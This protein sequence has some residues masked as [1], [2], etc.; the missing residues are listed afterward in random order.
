M[1]LVDPR[2]SVCWHIVVGS[3][4]GSFVFHFSCHHASSVFVP[5]ALDF[6]ESM[7]VDPWFEQFL[8]LCI[9][10]VCGLH[11]FLC[12]DLPPGMGSLSSSCSYEDV[13]WQHHYVLVVVLPLV[14]SWS[15]R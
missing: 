13:V 10:W 4:E 11:F 12:H 3:Y 5:H 6:L 9:Y 14:I 2:V 7:R 15:S 8:V 1:C